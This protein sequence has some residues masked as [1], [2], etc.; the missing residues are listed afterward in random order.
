ML[1][2]S[3][4]GEEEGKG[5]GQR[6]GNREGGKQKCSP[7]LVTDPCVV[8]LLGDVRNREPV[9]I[10]D[11]REKDRH[12]VQARHVMSRHAILCYAILS[13]AMSCHVL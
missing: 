13:Y 7:I 5:E 6:E 9:L 2:D 8:P 1:A 12:L 4:E 11:T 3:S 10:V